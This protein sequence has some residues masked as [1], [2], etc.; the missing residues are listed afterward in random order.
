MNAGWLRAIGVIGRTGLALVV[1][2]GVASAT[3]P[4]DANCDGEVKHDDIAALAR[5]LFTASGCDE[6]DV[7]ADGAVTA[8]DLA[9]ILEPVIEHAST[10]VVIL[11]QGDG[12]GAEHVR[13]G[14][15]AAGAPLHFEQFP[16]FVP[17]MDTSSLTTLETGEATD[18]AAG[19]SAF[20]TGIRVRNGEVSRTGNLDL[21]T[22]GELA[23]GA[24][25]SVGLVTNA[26]LFDA[27]PAAFVAHTDRRNRLDLIAEQYLALAP[28]VLIG[29]TPSSRAFRDLDGFIA[30]ARTRGYTV[31]RSA[32]EMEGL[33]LGQVRRLLALF[34]VDIDIGLNT[35]NRLLFPIQGTPEI[36]RTPGAL[37]PPLARSAAIAVKLLARNPFGFFLFVENEN[38]DTMS[39][40][41]GS[42]WLTDPR[43]GALVAGE[44]AG[45]SAVTQSVL[46]AL[47]ETGR[48]ADAL[49]VVT[50]DHETGGYTFPDD[51][52][53]AGTFPAA[54]S[55]T[56]APVPLYA[57]GNGAE[58][59][60]SVD[61]N[62]DV[63]AAM[64][65]R[66]R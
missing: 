33:D 25:K 14:A 52:P 38:I 11:V 62:I 26:F 48:Q 42:A 43:I 55:H 13:A 24:G 8:A 39:H 53:A 57:T 2:A 36:L 7:N 9:A 45:L 29:A 35:V 16:V 60:S 65:S 3:L 27:S 6:T 15:V 28:D 34:D 32:E 20:A 66:L 50:A 41:G 56:T 40:A 47:D 19:A 61:E 1:W 21:V 49:V 58:H 4:G 12:M 59:F 37:D 64:R 22:A 44:V 51:D 23:A 18:S 30:R 54:P 17:A 63:F 31:V 10:S 46:G 5:A